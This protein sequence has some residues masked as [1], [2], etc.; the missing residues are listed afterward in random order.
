MKA[1][2]AIA[3][4][5][6]FGAGVACGVAAWALGGALGGPMLSAL[7]CAGSIFGLLAVNDPGASETGP[8]KGLVNCFLAGLLI[9]SIPGTLMCLAGPPAGAIPGHG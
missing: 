4:L 9:G 7:L 6:I 1:L 8:I 5:A 3:G 2:F